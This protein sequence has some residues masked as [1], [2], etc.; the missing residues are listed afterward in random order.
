MSN[1]ARLPLVRLTWHAVVAFL[2]LDTVLTAAVIA[3]VV[4][5][6]SGAPATPPEAVAVR[7]ILDAQV[8]AWN[9]GD[10]DGFMAGYWKDDALT[11]FSGDTI[12]RGWQ[13][14]YDRY[15]QRYQAN[16]KEMGQLDFRDIDIQSLGGDAAVARGRWRLTMKDGKTPN[17]L[18]TLLFCRIDGHWRI[19]HDHTSMAEPK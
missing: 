8:T 2:I 15:R 4:G 17:G 9:R 11:F 6:A 7:A 10:L 1:T 18:F 16:G 3:A 19:V 14:T 12:T 13:A 5:L